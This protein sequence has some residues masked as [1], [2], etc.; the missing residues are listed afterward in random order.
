MA[1]EDDQEEP[2]ARGASLTDM[3]SGR[4]VILAVARVTSARTQDSVKATGV[5]VP[6][7]S[8][9]LTVLGTLSKVQQRAQLAEP[10]Q[11]YRLYMQE[12]E[13]PLVELAHDLLMR[14]LIYGEERLIAA[15]DALVAAA[16]VKVSFGARPIA[17]PV[18]RGSAHPPGLAQE[19]EAGR[20]WTQK[21]TQPGSGGPRPLYRVGEHRG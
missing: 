20:G 10:Q 7:V 21:E 1:P 16:R 2:S 8:K 13:G 19:E 3:H 17:E 4:L 11:L 9:K 6:W 5:V 18:E 12:R 14:D 15:P